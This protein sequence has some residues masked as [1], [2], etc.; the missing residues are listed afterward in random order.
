MLEEE[1]KAEAQQA[2]DELFNEYQL[3]FKLSARRVATIGAEEYIVYFHDGGLPS[4]A[5]SW[6]QGECFKDVF[7][8]A[9]LER[10]KKVSGPL[11][12]KPVHAEN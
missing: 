9:V 7:R 4:V 1:Q 3:P 6:Y 2:L 11:H 5:V 10:V 12:R 8:A